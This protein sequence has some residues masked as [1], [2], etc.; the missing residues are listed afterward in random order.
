[1]ETNLRPF[2][3]RR[4][5]LGVLTCAALSVVVMGL[6][7]IAASEEPRVGVVA[8][9]LGT[10]TV[11][12]T[13]SPEPAALRFKD[14]VFL[15]DRIRTA[16]R[17][18]VR[19]LLG[20]KATVTARERSILTITEIPSTATISVAVGRTAVAVSRAGLKPGETIEIKT[21]NSVVA[22]RGTFIVAEVSA[23]RST[24]TIVRG[25]VEITKLDPTS[26]KPVGSP[27]RVGALQRVTVTDAAPMP[28][29]ET[30]TPE[31]AKSLA[32][33][34]TFLPKDA[35]AAS[36]SALTDAVKAAALSDVTRVL[37]GG[38]SASALAGGVT[39]T[40]TNA[41]GA[42]GSL[43]ETV[44]PGT[45]SQPLVSLPTVLGNPVTA[46]GVVAP[47]DPTTLTGPIT[48]TV[49]NSFLSGRPRR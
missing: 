10:A 47:L 7:L 15:H 26:G 3:G 31:A 44:L 8:M 2:T 29:P 21:P 35:P 23:A 24:I 19:V 25:L 11:T 14:D 45:P 28:A 34:F 32:S 37:P 4:R 49:T 41:V 30:I 17:S 33:D 22:I 9:L 12:R 43:A 38:A 1:M 20:G 48:N 42:V 18:A 39:T 40:T 13:A 46:P 16:E 6:P 36:L 5:G 27:V